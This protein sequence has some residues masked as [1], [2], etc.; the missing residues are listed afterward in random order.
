[1]TSFTM[2]FKKH[3]IPFLLLPLL[4]M[5]CTGISQAER[6]RQEA[7]EE[8]AEL[9]DL[10]RKALDEGNYDKARRCINN[11]R[12]DVPLALDA[13][14]RGILLLDSIELAAASDSVRFLDGESWERLN[15]KVQFYT[16]K[17]KEDIKSYGE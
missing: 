7:E 6:N 8:G 2:V 4:V 15:L 9:L 3:Y 13:R 12:K 10:A 11:L 5:G 14:R 16:R 1:M 17:L